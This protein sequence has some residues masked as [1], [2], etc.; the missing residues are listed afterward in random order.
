MKV[1]I[2]SGHGQNRPSNSFSPSSSS[3]C[4]VTSGS[5]G[6]ESEMLGV[7]QTQG[8]HDELCFGAAG[9]TVRGVLAE[10]G[11]KAEGMK[12]ILQDLKTEGTLSLCSLTSH[13][14]AAAPPPKQRPKCPR[15]MGLVLG[16][17]REITSFPRK[18]EMCTSCQS[19]LRSLARQPRE[20]TIHADL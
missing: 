8:C 4:V 20:S 14:P 9:E 13:L 3:P 11:F 2:C 16:K 12:V 1:K 5:A 6:A 10:S 7:F 17:G 19:C 18:H 15:N